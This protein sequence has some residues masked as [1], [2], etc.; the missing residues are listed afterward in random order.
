VNSEPESPW[1]Y[2]AR[3]QRVRGPVN[4]H[5]LAIVLIVAPVVFGA[6]VRGHKFQHGDQREQSWRRSNG[7]QQDE[8]AQ[9]RDE[10]DER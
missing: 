5:T 4:R 7:S 8:A 6:L 2:V 3:R 9:Q 10:A 1:S